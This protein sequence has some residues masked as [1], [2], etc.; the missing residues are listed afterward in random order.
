M[1]QSGQEMLEESIT[2]CQSIVDGLS[3]VNEAWKASINEILE[4]FDEISGTFFFK[5]MPSVP[6]TRT[7][8]RD[9]TSA[10]ELKTSEDWDGFGPAIE[11]LIKSSQNVIEKAGMK[12]VTLT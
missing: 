2:N 5:T 7:V 9:S 12:G 1:P 10:L 11:Q 8:M 4:K 6:A 3:S